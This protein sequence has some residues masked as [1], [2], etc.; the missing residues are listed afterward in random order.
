MNTS[1]WSLLALFLV[2][3]GLLAWPLGRCA[4]GAVRRP[5][6]RAGCSA[7][8]RRSTG[9]PACRAGAVDALAQ[10]RAGA[11]RLQCA[12]RARRLRACSACKAVLPLNPAGMAAV[13]PDS[14]FNTAVSF[15]TNTNWQGYAGES[16]M[17]YLT[18]MLGAHGAELPLGRHRHRGGLR[19]G[20]RLRGARAPTA[21]A[22]VGNF[23]VD[24]T[25]IT[26]LAAAAA[27][28]RASRCSSR[29]RA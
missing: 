13:S 7:S 9:W 1:A 27:V 22:S 10:L 25:R 17:S 24:V 6:C 29:A 15:V 12:R 16:T 11:A 3:L 2:V 23:W 21:R 26:A 4:G 19:A 28:V 8:K 5:R 14:S 18:Q 20:A